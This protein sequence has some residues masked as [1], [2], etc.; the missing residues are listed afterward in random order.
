MQHCNHLHHLRILR[1]NDNYFKISER[2]AR[3]YFCGPFY[4]QKRFSCYK[5]EYSVINNLL[6]PDTVTYSYVLCT[7]HA[8]L[9]YMLYYICVFR[10]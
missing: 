3:R 10:C 4:T 1:L 2:F 5:G 6:D 8:S 9:N 7:Q